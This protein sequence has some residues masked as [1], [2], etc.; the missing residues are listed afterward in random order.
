[1]MRPITSRTI[2]RMLRLRKRA[3]VKRNERYEKRYQAEPSFLLALSKISPTQEGYMNM[4]RLSSLLQSRPILGPLE[5][6]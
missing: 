5:V 1:M 3:I 6:G 4:G 2:C